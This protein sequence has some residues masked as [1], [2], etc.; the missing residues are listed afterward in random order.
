MLEIQ[1]LSNKFLEVLLGCHL[2]EVTSKLSE[3]H[4]SHFS[5][6]F[7]LHQSRDGGEHSARVTVKNSPGRTVSKCGNL[8]VC[9]FL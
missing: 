8:K 5:L 9:A 4:S 2:P 6:L 1:A 3:E 7:F